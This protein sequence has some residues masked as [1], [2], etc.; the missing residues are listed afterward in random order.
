MSTHP[1][2]FGF[3]IAG[4][5]LQI[6]P[7]QCLFG[8]IARAV[9]TFADSAPQFGDPSRLSALIG[10]ALIAINTGM[11]VALVGAMLI[12]IAIYGK[13]YRAPWL[14]WLLIILGVVYLPAL[15]LGSLI[16]LAFLIVAIATR[17]TLLRPTLPPQA[18]H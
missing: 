18:N 12:L 7:V 14:F 15:P 3:A 4:A 17:K 6:F 2:G 13:R 8:T 1:K 5:I 16:G 11:L 10:E 9:R